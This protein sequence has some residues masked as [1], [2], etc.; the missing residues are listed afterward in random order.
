MILIGTIH[1]KHCSRCRSRDFERVKRPGIIRL[2]SG[3]YLKRY[4]C[5]K[6]WKCFYL[7]PIK[8]PARLSAK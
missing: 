8:G 6:C 4:K 2:L 7:I 1:E 5:A 3:S